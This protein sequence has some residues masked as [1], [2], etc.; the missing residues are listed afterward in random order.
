MNAICNIC[1]HHCNIPEGGVGFCRARTNK[2]GKIICKNYG[3]L[4]AMA[5][6]PIEKKPLMRYMPGSKILSIGSY[7]CNLRCPFC[8]NYEIS[9]SDEKELDTVFVSPKDLI[10]KA[11]EYVPAGN[12]GIAYTYNE[13]LISYEYIFDCARL[14]RKNGLK[15]IIV[16][17][18]YVCDKPFYELLPYIDAANIDLKAFSAVFYKKINGGLERVKQTIISAAKAC[19][20]EVT[21]LIIEGANDSPEEIGQLSEWL[22]GVG[23]EIPYHIS[24]FYPRYLYNEK[25]ATSVKA[26]YSLANIARQSLKYVYEGNC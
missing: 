13:P 5:V 21:T 20:V 19:H 24:R 10:K 22:A 23:N 2:N 4:T 3:K 8:Q 25:S 7:G 18:G 17:N 26:V 6:D 9:M 16:T 15:N 12:I 1:P 14:A 11:L